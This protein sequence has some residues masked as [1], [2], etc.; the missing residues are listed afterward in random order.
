MELNRQTDKMSGLGLGRV[1]WPSRK[2]P[3]S[4]R[5]APTEVPAT[6][7]VGSGYSRRAAALATPPRRQ[8]ATK[9]KATDAG[10]EFHDLFGITPISPVVEQ[11]RQ[12]ALTGEL[13][14]LHQ[15]DAKER[16]SRALERKERYS[17]RLRKELRDSRERTYEED[18]LPTSPLK[19]YDPHYGH[20]CEYDN[21]T[22]SD[23]ESPS[24]GNVANTNH[25]AVNVNVVCHH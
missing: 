20:G 15:L 7:R 17:R 19:D 14:A 18:E 24:R 25:G 23:E 6:W 22:S 21:G 10:L 11:L 8:P 16:V 9:R 1:G 5:L 4:Y 13:R 2:G 3:D 12:S